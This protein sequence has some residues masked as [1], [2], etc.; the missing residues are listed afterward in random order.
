MTSFF[1]IIKYTLNTTFAHK[2]LFMFLMTSSEST[3]RRRIR[4]FLIRWA[5]GKSIKVSK[6]LKVINQVSRC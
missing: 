5:Q 6:Y 2:A 1:P 3:S 4:L